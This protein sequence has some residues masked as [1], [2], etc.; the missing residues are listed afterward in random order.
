MLLQRAAKPVRGV[1]KD[2]VTKDL[3]PST[4]GCGRLVHCALVDTMLVLP[5]GK[6][7]G[8]HHIV[9]LSKLCLLFIDIGCAD[10]K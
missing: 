8:S 9:R 1:P 7:V 6:N 5:P 4:S 2:I 10:A 3:L